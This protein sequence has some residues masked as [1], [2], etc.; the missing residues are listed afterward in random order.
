MGLQQQQQQMM[1]LQQ[2]QQATAGMGLLQFDRVK[3]QHQPQQQQQMAAGQPFRVNMTVGPDTPIVQQQEQDESTV[4]QQQQ[5]GPTAASAAAALAALFAD[6]ETLVTGGGGAAGRGSFDVSL[7]ADQMSAAGLL[8]LSADSFA[9]EGAAAAGNSSLLLPTTLLFYQSMRL[10]CTMQYCVQA[11]GFV[12]WPDSILFVTR[13]MTCQS[14]LPSIAA[15]SLLC[16]ML[17][18]NAYQHLALTSGQ[19]LLEYH[20]TVLHLLL[21]IPLSGETSWRTCASSAAAAVASRQS[22]GQQQ[23]RRQ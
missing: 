4:Q 8:N 20:V 14:Q 10:C 3:M 21:Q 23:Q 16:C 5:Q 1:M 17:L 19:I 12:Q 2:Q 7:T 18:H 22:P 13:R 9:G 15:K 11:P 6:T